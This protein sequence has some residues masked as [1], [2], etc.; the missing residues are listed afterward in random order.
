MVCSDIQEG[1][2]AAQS[3]HDIFSRSF[4]TFWWLTRVIQSVFYK[5]GNGNM[6]DKFKGLIEFGHPTK[7]V[8]KYVYILTCVYI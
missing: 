2:C 7:T 3:D 5:G 1:G 8:C 4:S 6:E